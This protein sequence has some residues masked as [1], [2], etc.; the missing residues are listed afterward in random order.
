MA[1]HARYT[2]VL[3]NQYDLSTQS[4]SLSVAMPVNVIDVTTFQ[5]TAMQYIPVLQS[6]A[7]IAHSG[8][9]TGSIAGK[10]EKE[11]YTGMTTAVTVAA[12]LGTNTDACP[13]YVLPDTRNDNFTIDAPVEGVIATT[14]NWNQGTGVKRGLR[15]WEGTFSAAAP[16]PQTTPGYIDFGAA[17]TAGGFAYLF[18]QAIVGS[19]TDAIILLESDTVT[20]FASAATEATFTFSDADIGVQA[21]TLSGTINRY[22]R[23]SCTD[24]GGATSFTVVCVAGLSGITY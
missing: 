20:N 4:N 7:T 9:F 24:L 15:V 10:L 12:M 11:F 19:A 6:G 18:I 14:G 21:A 23:V 13:V 17:G 3:L 5:A 22:V 8:Y 1:T 16:T 2:K